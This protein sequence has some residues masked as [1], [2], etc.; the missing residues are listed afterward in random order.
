MER[1]IATSGAG[2]TQLVSPA[3]LARTDLR[4]VAHI[5]VLVQGAILVARTLEAIVFLAFVGP[6]SSV[7]L[8]LTAGA[9]LLTLATAAGLARGS[10]RARRWTLVA[11]SGVLLVGLVDLAF[12]WLMTGEPLGPVGLLGGLVVPAVVVAILRRR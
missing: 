4:A 9:A 1:T 11:E 3:P 2:V 6:A 12:A 10:A 7:S 8:G 5:L